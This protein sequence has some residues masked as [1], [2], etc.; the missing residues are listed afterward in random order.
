MMSYCQKTFYLF[1]DMLIEKLSLAIAFEI[2][3]KTCTV[4]Y[5]LQLINRIFPFLFKLKVD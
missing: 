3:A 4:S 1:S 5:A 2:R